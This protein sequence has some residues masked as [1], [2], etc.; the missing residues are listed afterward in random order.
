M[1]AN[2]L[3]NLIGVISPKWH[4][5]RVYH[6]QYATNLK[7]I[8]ADR[9]SL[10][11]FLSSRQS[12]YEAGKA[13][14]LKGRNA[15]SPHENDVPRHQ[16]QLLRYRSWQL[17]RNN[18]QA[19]KIIRNLNAKVIGQG[20]DPQPQSTTK[21]G[22][23]FAAFRQRARHVWAQF[24]KEADFRGKPGSGG[25]HFTALSKSALK[26]VVLS[27]GVLY[28]F[29]KL[30]PEEQKAAGLFI[31][32]Q[33]QLMHVDRLDESKHGDGWHHGIKLDAKGRVVAMQIIV[34]GV[35]SEQ[36]FTSQPSIEVSAK[37]LKHLFAEED[38]DQLLGSPWMGA[39]ML[40]MDDRRNY[41]YHELIAAEMAAC[42]VA[43]YRRAPGKTGGP[44]LSSG[45]ERDLVDADGN[46][47]TR[48]QPGMFM[49]LGATGEIQLLNPA[50]P[51]ANAGE[52]ISHLI[53]SEAVGVPG[54]KTSTLTGD[55]RQSSFSSERSADNDIW[56]EIEE[57][58]CW[59]SSGFCQ[60][61]YEECISAA[62]LAGRFS[63]VEGFTAADFTE[64][65]REFLE[66]NWQ[67]PVPRS[68]NPNDDAQAASAR[69]KGGTSSPQRENSQI[70]RDW[71]EI[72]RE[73][74]EFIEHCQELGLPDQYWQNALGIQMAA[75]P[76]PAADEPLT[77]EGDPNET[78]EA[79]P[80][81][82]TPEDPLEAV[83]NRLRGSAFVSMNS[84]G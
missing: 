38:I 79:K 10:H 60:P 16:I 83:V 69:V 2:F 46:P 18:P 64:R 7:N 27:G 66:A 40:T 24:I 68:I 47:V 71:R 26:A 37:E 20:L 34:G 29:H 59:F 56:P 53:R 4:A 84:A 70:G 23:P 31:P 62:V 42:L 33:L 28:R 35:S 19:K 11:K 49:D 3:D 82:E 21:D 58:Q 81:E 50:R 6:R 1:L 55:Y 74:D 48:L 17:W 76:Q 8:S 14:R 75:P 54:V 78:G 67:G 41:E 13:D 51:N 22:K 65:K 77:P 25:H 30:T 63:D 12:G 9:N 5:H 73:V 43:G 72:A 44:G 45:G 80:E 61:I 32:L 15:G 52:F 39:S 36:E 57:L